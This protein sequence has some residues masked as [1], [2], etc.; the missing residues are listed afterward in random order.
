MRDQAANGKRYREHNKGNHEFCLP[1][2]CKHALDKVKQAQQIESE[3]VRVPVGEY[4]FGPRG[5]R[6]Y[7]DMAVYGNLEPQV[8]ILVVEMC[9]VVDRLHKLDQ[10]IKGRS[11]WIYPVVNPTDDTEYTL[12]VDNALA[13]ARH[14]VVALKSLL[15]EFRMSMAN[16]PPER[17]PVAAQ[18]SVKK[19]IAGIKDELLSRREQTAS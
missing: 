4:Q 10:T 5:A 17:Q 7:K 14:Q 19:G 9:H 11:Q 3:N 13:E 2:N 15:S 1:N 12:V 16:R 18:V 8:H 6:L